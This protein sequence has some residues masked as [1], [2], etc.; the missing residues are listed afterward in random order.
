MA[1][2]DINHTSI[3]SWSIGDEEVEQIY[4]DELSE[5]AGVLHTIIK[6]EDSSTPT[7]ASMN[8]AQPGKQGSPLL[9]F[10]DVLTI[11]Y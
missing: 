8:L 4:C 5:I 10:L 3:I 2:R 6:D 1:S 9:G 11:N 7:T